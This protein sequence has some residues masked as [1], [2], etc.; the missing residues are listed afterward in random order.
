MANIFDL[1]KKV[2][3]GNAATQGGPPAYLIVGLGNPGQ[4]YSNTRH[5]A[6]FMAID[7][8][9]ETY[10]IQVNRSRFS[11]LVGDGNVNGVRVLLMKPQTMMNAS[12][13][14]VEEAVSFYRIPVEHVIVLSDD[15]SLEPGRIRVRRSGSAGGHNGLKSINEQLGSENYPRMRIGVGKKPSPD[16]DLADWVLGVFLPSDREKIEQALDK[17]CPGLEKL[18]SGD[19]DAAMQICNGK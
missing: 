11:S 5:N 18:L 13:D 7:R 9:A 15:I 12:G 2:E 4:R 10:G 1:F 16:Y 8:I 19:V 17:I 6:G 3:A 14:A